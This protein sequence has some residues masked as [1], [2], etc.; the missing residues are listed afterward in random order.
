MMVFMEN[1]FCSLNQEWPCGLLLHLTAVIIEGIQISVQVVFVYN[2]LFLLTIS[3]S[4][5]L[6]SKKQRSVQSFANIQKTFQNS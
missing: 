2:M 3:L 6:W 5:E 1:S 4:I